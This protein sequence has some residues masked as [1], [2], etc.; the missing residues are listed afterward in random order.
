MAH[1]A[2]LAP[3][4][5]GHIYPIGSLAAELRRRGHQTTLVAL[6]AAA[7]LAEKLDLPLRELRESAKPPRPSRAA[8]IASRPLG[9]NWAANLR[10][11]FV[12]KSEL[13]LDQAPAIIRDLQ[14]DAVIV[15]QT[16]LAGGSVAESLSLPFATVCSALM[17]NEEPQVPPHFTGWGFSG[18]NWARYRNR[19]GYAAWEAYMRATVRTINRYRGQWGLPT[20]RRSTQTISPYLQLSQLCP[21]FDF[22]RRELASTCHYVG[23]LAMARPPRQDDFPWDRLD[24]RPLIFASLGTV[25]SVSNFPVYQKIAKACSGLDAQLVLSLGKWGNKAGDA[26]ARLG[27]LAGDPIVVDF[28]PQLALLQ[29]ASLLITHAGQNTTLEALHFGVP[30]VALPRSA[31]QPAMA[32]RLEHAGVALRGSFWKSTPE[33]LRKLVNRVLTEPHFR[34]RADELRQALSQTGGAAH[35]ADLIEAMLRTGKPITNARTSNN[36]RSPRN[37]LHIPS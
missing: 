13:V 18:G 33:G 4:A 14:A 35:A 16:I 23:P 19:I 3:E 31:D 32:A 36:D 15:D 29:K 27:R 28:A 5:G 12:W 30:M 24:G 6:A 2:L 1:F 26:R 22:P 8:A 37:D 34:Q 17:W 20:L 9:L 21:E 11:R 7:P 25:P 10:A